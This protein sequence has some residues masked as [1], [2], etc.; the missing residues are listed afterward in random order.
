VPYRH[1]RALLTT[2][3]DAAGTLM[4][5]HL[6][7]TEDQQVDAGKLQDTDDFGVLRT[8]SRAAYDPVRTSTSG[9]LGGVSI[10]LG[11]PVATLWM[12]LRRLMFMPR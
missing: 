7:E 5:V 8:C 12:G 10:S 3:K 11:T 9:R 6:V 4:V 2:E 1:S